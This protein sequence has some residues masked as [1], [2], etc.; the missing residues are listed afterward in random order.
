M[1]KPHFSIEL[2][3]FLDELGRNNRREW[4]EANRSRYERHVREPML[5]FIAAS[6]R[7]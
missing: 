2:F 5:G 6:R 3:R 1:K 4:F 7:A